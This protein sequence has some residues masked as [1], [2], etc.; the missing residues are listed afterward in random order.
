MITILEV[1][2]ERRSGKTTILKLIINNYTDKKERLY[3][4]GLNF[5]E[6]RK[7]M[8][9]HYDLIIIDESEKVSENDIKK[10]IVPLLNDGGMLILGKL[11]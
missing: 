8:G 6:P 10:Y 11:I 4:S 2:G 1:R 3:I 5:P 9:R 7:L